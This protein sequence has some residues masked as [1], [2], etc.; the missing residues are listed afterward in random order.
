[1]KGRII[2]SLF[3]LP[4][5]SVGLWMLW[6]VSAMLLG[7]WQAQSWHPVPARLSAAGYT[8][9][10]GEDSDSYE[11]YASYSYSYNGQSF[12]GNR[13]SFSAGSDNI[14]DYQ[15]GTG[16][17]LS[18]A[19]AREKS[20]MVMV[21]PDAP[22]ES[23][24]DPSVRWG[25]LGF[26]SIFLFVFG[27]VG[28]GLLI[29]IWRAPREKD[30][31]KPEYQASPWLLNHDWQSASI[32]SSSKLGMWGMWAFAAIWSLISAPMPF[33]A[34]RE[35]IEKENYLAIAALLFPI[36]GIGLIGWAVKLTREWRRFGPTPVTLDPFPGSIGG[37]VGGTIDLHLPFDPGNRF[38]ITLN[39][40]HS[41]ISGSGKSRS[42]RESALW[43]DEI[44]GHAE[45][46]ASG[47]RITF[48]FDVPEGQKESDATKD[49]K[50]YDLWRLNV[51]AELPGANLDRD[52]EIPVYATAQ[53]SGSLTP[54]RL[55]RSRAEQDAYYDQ[56]IRRHV[57][58][59]ST[60]SGKRLHY[61]MFRK[62]VS[63]G[64][65]IL[66][67]GVFA[68]VGWVMAVMEGEKIFGAVFGGVG[69]IVAI[70]AFY[71]LF[72]SLDIV[73]SSDTITSV[74]RVL[75][76]PI[77]KRS[78]RVSEF[79]RFE[80]DNGMQTQSGKK[81]TIH[82]SVK[83]IDRHAN[84]MILGEAFHGQTAAA[85][86]V[87]MLEAELGLRAT[88]KPDNDRNLP[89]YTTPVETGAG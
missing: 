55:E 13:V 48:R 14:G 6:S 39:N 51:R 58:I 59:T 30:K 40:L 56:E 35:I 71:M 89:S 37:H 75:G 16:R 21:N 11:A 2:G 80:I 66:I 5:F 78:M 67:G 72:K 46:S 42:R 3:A 24:I 41:Y 7:S 50:A 9:S 74:R 38:L 62:P 88:E 17:E 36:V 8:T 19:L 10:R 73:Q 44:L 33:I 84:E 49:G 76:I 83:A 81:H 77:R 1:M 68:S 23:I 82:L 20:I 85:A 27:G 45:S 47:T 52:F 57:E 65:A 87:R 29:A 15:Q 69:A 53:T 12:T 4:F 64:A 26:K 79:H 31:S 61:P 34:Y 43:Q 22:N 25:L 70:T 18:G 54:L 32:R 28:L 86:A 63:N 60:G